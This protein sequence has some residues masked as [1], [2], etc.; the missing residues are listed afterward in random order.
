MRIKVE[1]VIRAYE[2]TGIIPIHS[3]WGFS[4]NEGQAC[5][6]A[7]TALAASR[8]KDQMPPEQFIKQV[9][10]M[11]YGVLG[12]INSFIPE[13]QSS[14]LEGFIDG[15][16]GVEK[17]LTMDDVLYEG[18]EENEVLN[19][20]NGYEDGEQVWEAVYEWKREEV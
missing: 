8:A 5:G 18:V 20:L 4:T 11:R 6:C 1:D 19:Y 2:E 3:G 7:L 13:F 12:F 17:R 15:F 16:D 14:Y 9:A 10:K